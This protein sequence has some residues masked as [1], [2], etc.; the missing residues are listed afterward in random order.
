MLPLNEK[1]CTLTATKHAFS[2]K[3]DIEIDF[4]QETGYEKETE[5]VKEFTSIVDALNYLATKGWELASSYN[6][7]RPMESWHILR[8]KA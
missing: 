2:S 7:G 4:G 5:I 8:R 3:V 1:Y 6:T